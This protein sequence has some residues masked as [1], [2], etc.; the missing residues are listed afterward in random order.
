MRCDDFTLSGAKSGRVY[1]YNGSAS[2]LYGTDGTNVFPLG[3]TKAHTFQADGQLAIG[4]NV[5]AGRSD[6]CAQVTIR[7]AKIRHCEDANRTTFP[8]P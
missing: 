3:T 4:F 7:S 5:E 1:S 2:G 8:C 6:Y